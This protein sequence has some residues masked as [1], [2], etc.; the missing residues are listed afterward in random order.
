MNDSVT[1]RRFLGTSG[2]V[3]AGLAAG[4]SLAA[5]QQATAAG[6]NEKLTIGL[7]GSGGMGRYKM[8]NFMNSGQCDVAAVCDVDDSMTDAAASLVTEQMGKTPKKIKD[9]RQLLDMKEIDAVII[10]TPD[11]WHAA[12][13]L[14]ACQAGK[15]VYCEK[16]CCHNI[17]E[18]RA[19]LD[20]AK[21]YNRVV[22]IGTH[23]RSSPHI[24]QAR[25]FIQDGRLGKISMTGT[26]TS[27]NEYPDGMGD[28]PNQDPPPGVDYDMWLGPAPKRPFNPRRFHGSWRWYF[29][30][31]CGMVGDWNVHLQDIIMWTLGTPHPVAVSASGGHL[32]LKDDRTTPDTM[33]AVYEFGPTDLAPNGYVHTYT[34]RKA[35]GKPWNA[36]G[37]G[38]EF[39]GTNGYCHVDRAGWKVDADRV[40]WTDPKSLPR[41]PSFYIQGSNSHQEHADDFIRCVKQG[42]TPVAS[43]E[44]HYPTVV[45]CHLANVSLLVGRKIFWDHERELCFKDRG[46]TIEDKEANVLL[47]REYRKGYELPQV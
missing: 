45:A 34:L 7:I 32:L 18:G 19:M 12:P 11:H 4:A 6:P 28:A 29:D 38:M 16:P 41:I 25:Q 15:E 26:Y 24:Q 5:G 22:Q 30:Y 46:L 42:G 44:R 39:H 13:M 40:D 3:A 36:G 43:M 47:G 8:M 14:L 1:R 10:A 23:Q 9:F 37:Y 35:S 17:R 21:K 20:A 33:T 27:G 31:G 2:Q